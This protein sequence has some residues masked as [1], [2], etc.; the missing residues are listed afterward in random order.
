M[1]EWNTPVREPWNALI[2][3]ALNAIDRHEEFYRKTGNGWHVQKAH[4][5]RNYVAELKTWIHEQEKF[6][7]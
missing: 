1:R 2:K 3:Q 7:T 6:T 5:L 4:Q